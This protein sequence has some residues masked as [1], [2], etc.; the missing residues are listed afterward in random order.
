MNTQGIRVYL[1]RNKDGA[2]D[3]FIKYKNEV[4]NQ[5]SKKI[6]RLRIDK[7]GEYESNPFNSFCEDHE[8]IQK[9]T[10]PYSP[11]SNGVVERKNRT[12]KEIMNAM[13]VSSGTPLNLW[14]EAILSTCHIQNRIPYKKTGKNPYEL[15]K[16]YVP[17]IAS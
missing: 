1:L 6:K 13:L 2:R 14:G 5:L 7:G 3:A 8:I 9:T 15:W 10:P 4:K 12:L 16:G 17:N 11:E